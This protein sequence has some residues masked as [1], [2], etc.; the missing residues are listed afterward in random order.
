MD[1]DLPVGVCIHQLDGD[2]DTVRSE[3]LALPLYG[4]EPPALSLPGGREEGRA[5]GV[6]DG[7][8]WSGLALGGWW[9]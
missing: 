6:C 3:R 9:Y 4:V 8:R 2:E 7:E 5:K 1:V